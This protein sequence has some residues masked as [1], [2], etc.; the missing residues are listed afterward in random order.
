MSLNAVNRNLDSYNRMQYQMMRNPKM[1]RANRLFDFCDR[2]N[3]VCRYQ[4]RSHQTYIIPIKTDFD[5]NKKYFRRKKDVA[6]ETSPIRRNYEVIKRYAKVPTVKAEPKVENTLAENENQK[7]IS[8]LEQNLKRFEEERCRFVMEKEKFEKERRQM[9]QVRFQ[10]LIE[11]E[12]KRNN[13]IQQ[14]DAKRLA[15]EAA[16]IALA[17]I[18]NQRMLLRHRRSKSKSRDSSRTRNNGTRYED[19]YVSSTASTVSSR[20]ADFDDEIGIQEVTQMNGGH[21][22]MNGSTFESNEPLENPI[23]ESSIKMELR[24]SWLSRLVFGKR[25]SIPV[26]IVEEKTYRH[27]IVDDGGPISIKRILTIEAPLV[28]QQMLED[29]SKDWEIMMRVRNRCIAHFVLLLML[30]GSGGLIFRFIEGAF[31]NF[32]KCGVRRV[33]REFVDQLWDSSHDMRE[34]DWKDLARSKLRGFEE[35]LHNAH[36]AGLR[37]YSG[38][39]AWTF[40]NGVVFCMTVVTTIGEFCSVFLFCKFLSNKIH[41]CDGSFGFPFIYY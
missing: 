32:Y 39:N 14:R 24:Q 23:I 27:L 34:D 12:R 9:E 30:V 37:S 22:N 7:R 21:S 36:E 16:A 31:E 6:C 29:H 13:S 8:K 17:E 1:I 26:R 33:K 2:L 18:E 20:A 41:F 4:G 10:R 28:W 38:L 19:D 25:T 15:V 40:T 35:E 5:T 3:E 11:F